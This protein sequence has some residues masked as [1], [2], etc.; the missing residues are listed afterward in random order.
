MNEVNFT[1]QIVCTSLMHYV[2]LLESK[3]DKSWYTGFSSDLR[4]RIKAH[5]TGSGGRIT[6]AKS[7]LKLIYYE[8]YLSQKDALGREKFLKSGSEG[9][10]LKK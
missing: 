5:N 4:N 9:R 6:R 8:S 3:V 10:Y 1:G 2:Y 7:F